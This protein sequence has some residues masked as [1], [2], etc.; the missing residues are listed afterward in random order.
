VT[1]KPTRAIHSMQRGCLS[2]E[3]TNGS[4]LEAS[5]IR[6]RNE[7][8]TRAQYPATSGQTVKNDPKHF[9]T[10]SSGGSEHRPWTEGKPPYS[11]IAVA[12]YSLTHMFHP[13][14][15]NGC[16]GRSSRFRISSWSFCQ[17]P[18]GFLSACRIVRSDGPRAHGHCFLVIVE[19]CEPPS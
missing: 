12:Q 7:K 11:G 19:R 6:G 8:E 1:I 14:S 9:G 10:S 15:F 17:H 18:L 3:N 2:V 4:L 13:E 5:L 16:S